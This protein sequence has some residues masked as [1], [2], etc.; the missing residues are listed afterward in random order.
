M[1]NQETENQIEDFLSELNKILLDKT[2]EEIGNFRFLY[3]KYPLVRIGIRRAIL[4]TQR[5]HL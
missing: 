3:D 5:R 1:I 4:I 2:A